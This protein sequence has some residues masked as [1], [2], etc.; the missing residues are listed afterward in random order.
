MKKIKG[1]MIDTETLAL[2]AKAL[3]WEIACVPFEIEIHED[4]ASWDVVGKP[5]HA[6]IDYT[7]LSTSGF[8]IDL[9]TIN[10]TAR[11][12]RGDPVWN[13]WREKHFNP[14]VDLKALPNPGT[15]MMNPKDILFNLKWMTKDAPVWFRNSAFDVPVIENLASLVG[16][17]TP[18]HRRQQ[19]DLYTQVNMASQLY[20]YED[21]LPGKSGHRALDD[22]MAQISQLT[23]LSQMLHCDLRSENSASP[24]F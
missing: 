5:Y 8:D 18:W 17:E 9:G 20:G 12:R 2:G 19:S 23:E 6:M 3:A 15:P 7:S 21:N 4:H 1:S 14:G 13:Y 16:T 24:G 22:A 10:W 11:Q